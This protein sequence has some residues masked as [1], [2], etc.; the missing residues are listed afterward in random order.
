M[1]RTSNGNIAR[2]VWVRSSNGQLNTISERRSNY[3]DWKGNVFRLVAATVVPRADAGCAYGE[4]PVVGEPRLVAERFL[5]H[6]GRGA[7]A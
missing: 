5:A 2:V 6:P 7:L 1:R 4:Q 3:V